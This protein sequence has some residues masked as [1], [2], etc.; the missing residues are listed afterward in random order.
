MLRGHNFLEKDR[1]GFPM[2][3]RNNLKSL[4]ENLIEPVRAVS[5]GAKLYLVTYDSPALADLREALAPDD[6]LVLDANGSTQCE[7]YK[8]G[9]KRVIQHSDYDALI[10]TRFDLDF[11]KK[12]NEWNLKVTN[13]S[14]LFPWRELKYH[15][16]DHKRVGDGVHVIGRNAIPAFHNAIIMNQLSGR[17]HMHMMYYYLR[18]MHEELGFIEDGYW[19]S[20]TLFSNPEGDNPLYKIFNRPKLDMLAPNTGR[21]IAEIRAE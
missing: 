16:R 12:F 14:I 17:N 15:W 3:A 6:C 19:D 9:L 18:T 11:R 13:N 20:N 7:T 8:E 2:D 5:P 21:T 10:A 4:I 1:F